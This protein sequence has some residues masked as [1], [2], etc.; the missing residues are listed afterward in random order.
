M[1][2]I[3]VEARR[4]VRKVAKKSL[5][6]PLTGSTLDDYRTVDDL[7]PKM[8]ARIDFLWEI[9]AEFGIDTGGFDTQLSLQGLIQ[10][11][12]KELKT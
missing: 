9:S 6:M 7:F 5:G 3:K 11:V 10:H 1:S 2:I 12:V 8:E 4:R